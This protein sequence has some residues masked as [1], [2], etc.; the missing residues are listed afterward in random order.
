[1]TQFPS[2]T[3]QIDL[4]IYI[5]SSGVS[6]AELLKGFAVKSGEKPTCHTHKKCTYMPLSGTQKMS[7]KCDAI[8]GI[9]P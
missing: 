9:F 6:K 2:Y 3:G 1:M 5:Y 4:L 8:P 7:I